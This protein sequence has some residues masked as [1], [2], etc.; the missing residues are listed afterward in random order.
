MRTVCEKQKEP[1][2]AASLGHVWADRCLSKSRTYRDIPTLGGKKRKVKLRRQTTSCEWKTHSLSLQLLCSLDADIQPEKARESCRAMHA[3]PTF[4]GIFN[5]EK[6]NVS[7][8][9]FVPLAPLP[10]SLLYFLLCCWSKTLMAK[11]FGFDMA[12]FNP[13]RSAT[14]V[15]TRSVL[16]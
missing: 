6:K 2:E 15:E 14:S 12:S 3:T 8:L 9:L 10:L 1:L 7:R 4:S 11:L 16:P 13:L 5:D